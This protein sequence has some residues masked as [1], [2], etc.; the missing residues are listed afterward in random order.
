[1]AINKWHDNY[2]IEDALA[3][4][5]P[6]RKKNSK[7]QYDSWQVYLH[8]QYRKL[9]IPILSKRME[10]TNSLITQRLPCSILHPHLLHLYLLD[11]Y[12]PG[13]WADEYPTH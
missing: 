10:E 7:R 12:N 6:L 2:G 5:K 3:E 8:H 11:C 4:L 13:I 9:K 1:M